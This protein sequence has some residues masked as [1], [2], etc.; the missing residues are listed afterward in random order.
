M[1]PHV[2]DS[3]SNYQAYRLIPLPS[4]LLLV[5]VLEILKSYLDTIKLLA[6]QDFAFRD[7]EETPNSINPGNFIASCSFCQGMIHHRQSVPDTHTP[8]RVC[9]DGASC[10]YSVAPVCLLA[11]LSLSRLAS[12]ST[13]SPSYIWSG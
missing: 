7:H 2:G 3:R 1:L 11:Y 12:L 4:F 6:S 9:M 5:Y 13:G 10:V 8:H